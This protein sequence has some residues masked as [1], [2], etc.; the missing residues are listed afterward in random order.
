MCALRLF[1]IAFV[2]FPLLVRSTESTSGAAEEKTAES[3]R[4]GAGILIEKKPELLTIKID[5]DGEAT[6]YEFAM[7]DQKVVDELKEVF[8]ACRVQITFKQDGES[9]KLL[10]IKRQVTKAAGTFTGD[11]VKVHND[12]WI[13]VKPKIGLA[14][15]FAPSVEFWNDKTFMQRL[16]ELQPGESVTITYTTDFERHRIKAMRKNP[17]AASKATATKASPTK[18][19]ATSPAPAPPQ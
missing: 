10:G 4:K 15:A 9:R 13:E 11:V 14:D 6:K 7:T 19:A 2:A 3:F 18:D 1:V 12:F 16:K 17:P 5:G 8:D